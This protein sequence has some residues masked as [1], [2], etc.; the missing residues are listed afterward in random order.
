[1]QS[2][3][4][5]FCAGQE[6]REFQEQY[7]EVVRNQ[8][9][10]NLKITKCTTIGP[11]RIGK[12]CLKHLLTGQKWD[13]E[14][15]TVST[16]VMEAP[17]WVECYSVE[18]GGAEELWKLVS[19]QQQHGELIR[20]V[21]TLTTGSTQLKTTPSDAPLTTTPCDAPPT[22]SPSDVQ[23]PTTPSDAP[24]TTTLSD[25]QHLTTPSDVQHPNTLS[26][27]PST[28]T[29]RYATP[30]TKASDATI[31]FT[32]SDVEF[33]TT[34]RSAP[35]ATIK[36][37]AVQKPA[38]VWQALE[39]LAGA[40]SP[41]DLQD[42]LKDKAGKVLGETRLVHFIDTGGQ[43]VYHDVHPVLITSPSVYL[44]VFSLED[45]YQKSDKEQ[46]KYFRSDLIQ[47]PLRSIYTFGMKNSQEDHLLVHPEAPTIFIVGTHLDKIPEKD[48]EETLSKLH[49][50]I[51]KEI[52]N[53]PYRQFIQYDTKGRSFW[54]VDNTL[55]GR[56][57]SEEFKKYISTLRMM[58]QEK[59]MEMSVKVPLPWMLLKLVMDGK[60]VRYCR[61]SE[62]LEE[63][64]IR[65]YVREHSAS[66][67]LDTML[68][69]FHILS[70]LYHKVPKGY[71]K[72]DSLVFI[73]PDCLYSV[74]SD[75]LMAS[76]EEMEDSS[77]D[78]HWTQAATKEE[79]EN[80]QG[81]SEEAQ[82]ET[83]AATTEKYEDNQDYSDMGQSQTQVVTMEKYEDNQGGS[84]EGQHQ[85]QGASTEETEDSQGGS[86]EEQRQTQAATKEEAE[87]SQGDSEK[88]KHQNQAATTEETEDSLDSQGGSEEKQRQTQAAT[89]E[90]AENSQENSEEEK[91]QNQAAT[92]EETENSQG[93]SEE[94]QPETQAAT[95]E[96]YEDNQDGSDRGQSK[97]QV[98]TMEKYE[99]N[100]GGSEERQH[101]AQAASTEKTE[102]ILD[103]QA[104]SEEGQHQTQT[105]T[106][107]LEEAED[108]L[109]GS[110]ED[111]HQIHATTDEETEDSQ[112]GSEEGQY[113]PQ[114]TTMEETE[115]SH[116][117]SEE[118]QHLTQATTME[119]TEDN[120]GGSEEGQYQPQA[121]TMEETEDNQGGSEEGQ[122]QTRAATKEE[123]E[124]NQGGSEEGQYQPQ[125]TTM[126][127]T[128]DN[129]GGS[130]EEQRQTQAATT[131]E[132][133]DSLEGSE[134][135]K[136]QN[137][138][139]T[140]EKYQDNQEG[141]EKR[142]SQ[143]QAVTTEKTEDILD[144]QEDSEEGQH[145]TQAATTEETEN[146]Q[147]G[148][149]EEQHRTQATTLEEA[150][151]SQGD[152][153]EG[154]L[155]TQAGSEEGQHQTQTATKELEEAADS[156][157]GSE[158][159]QHQI[160]AT[161]DEET[162]DSQGGS[163]EGQHLT[164]ATTME[165]TEDNQGGSEEGQY[166]PQATT[167]EE[168]EDNQGG[169]EEGQYQP[170][171]T[172]ME[173][174]EDNQGGS[175]EG[176]YQPQAV[177]ME[178]RHH[179][180]KLAGGRRQQMLEPV[181]IVGKQGIIQ[182][183]EDNVDS[184][185]QEVEAVVQ[186][187]DGTKARID[188]MCIDLELGKL[189]AQLKEISQQHRMDAIQCPDVSF[190]KAKRH[191]F[192]GRLIHNL[193]S[194]MEAVLDDSKSKADV[195]HV[196]D[197]VAKAVENVRAC[198][199]NRSIYSHDIDQ[200]LAILSDLRIVARLSDSNSYVVPAALPKVPHSM[201]VARSA[202]PSG[203]AASILFT[204]VSRTIM[205]VCF[206]PSGLFCC[207]ISELV[208]EAG[209]T[210][211]PLE[212]THVAFTH[213]DLSGKV[214]VVEHESYIEIK[215]ESKASLQ[216]LTH[217][218]QSVRE[219]IHK[220]VVNVYKNL[221]SDPTNDTT[222]E[223]SLVW[224]FQCK[225]HPDDD[226]HIAAFEEDEYE[227]YAECLLPD[228][229]AL[230]PVTEAQWVWGL[231][232]TQL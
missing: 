166:Q 192:I 71:K 147:G 189:H 96:K 174:A 177:A 191:L 120:Q 97:T 103:S 115:V 173:E 214:H 118:G 156:L 137:Q 87:N 167:M 220:H 228:S 198:Y 64:C 26:D 89:T 148:S 67:D 163:E 68:W 168:T 171:A 101:Q 194:S 159:D 100:Q 154:Q 95:T 215:L 180:E 202:G 90:E 30:T 3:F 13:V 227:C 40:C 196:K 39:A 42:F 54:A 182:R 130:E 15:G 45:F 37:D 230:Q 112:G 59:S 201:Q 62:L 21:N 210:V 224:G 136:H 152:S 8:A 108:S 187:V 142:Q 38:T 218:C 16:D 169:S 75:F 11:P 60:Q 186:I 35:S 160:H 134:V 105:A 217:T 122:R 91:H 51:S 61:Y 55:A 145:Q 232:T 221:Y 52:G 223:E 184:I 49:K 36:P 199:Q 74:T 83:Q 138:A 119:E 125:A 109:G 200:L 78:Q 116:G 6:L 222:F 66:A 140:T 219:K 25:A 69:L 12:T 155:Q 144:S 226:T 110:E 209:W 86:E 5:I 172:T 106:K 132:A 22:S 32:P 27:A 104:G 179:D 48:C 57:Q 111:Q 20:A 7:S 170:Q 176:Q 4:T 29:P 190:Q 126:E 2:H 139:A 92:T 188:K 34:P 129:Q 56:E 85:A 47:R 33:R 183:M 181:R 207:L 72:E 135:G 216:E 150:E 28:T 63:A 211:I 203:H 9:S 117:G 225:A 19:K 165:E 81:D 229:N 44:V 123:A 99:D 175:E 18:E 131:E 23:H 58:V 80:S 84:E 127:E 46:L 73:D 133:E 162:E 31:T 94:A 149:E 98:V 231:I 102:D 53:K 124:D 212:R 141:S 128:E 10:I 24:P 114:A 213:K 107:E 113:Q 76:K 17:E 93:A 121:T 143:I 146:I 178:G 193:A 77:K 164:Q 158:E 206:L 205:Q 161:T 1:M 208:T 50:M 151:N 195:H 70:L 41:E 79:A 43:A 14:A 157:G 204:V 185:K 88:G 153:E 65:G 82:P 197:E